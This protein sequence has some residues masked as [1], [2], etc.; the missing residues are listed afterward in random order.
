MRNV[1]RITV[2]LLAVV[3]LV[4]CGAVQTIPPEPDESTKVIQQAPEPLVLQL[5]KALQAAL[6]RAGLSEDAL[7]GQ[8]LIVVSAEGN[9]A[10]VCCFEKNEQGVWSQVGDSAAAKV[11]RNGVSEKKTEGDKMTP[12]GLFELGF[13]FGNE[14]PPDGIKMEF[15]SV[16][17]DSYW[18]DDGSSQYY[19]QWV[20]GTAHQDWAS[21]EHLADYPAQYALAVVVRYNMDPP[22]P[23][24][25][26]AIFLHCGSNPT[27]GCIAVAHDK[28]A[29]ILLWLDQEKAPMILIVADAKAPLS[30]PG[31]ADMGNRQTNM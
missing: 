1:I 20:E 28:M 23:G 3:L 9:D 24:A 19:N 26:S 16:T 22:V 6:A 15:R 21:A 12:A 18:V 17:P 31:Q 8:Q 13:A 5:P 30:K 2:M 7:T 29:K 27:L 4:G 14:T 11:G 10:E 25:G